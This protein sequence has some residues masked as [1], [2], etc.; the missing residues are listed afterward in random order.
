MNANA[1]VVAVDPG[2]IPGVAVLCVINGVLTPSPAV[3]QCGARSVAW[4]VD[5]MFSDE[6]LYEQRILVIERFVVGPRAARSSTPKAGQLTRDMVGELTA[7]GTQLGVRVVQRSA[8]EVM[9]WATDARLDRA[10]LL[11]VTKGMQHARAA[12]RHALFCAVRDCGASDPLS[13]RSP[14]ATRDGA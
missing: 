5:Q 1:L 6:P 2:P 14:T 3:F 11:A 10:G 8:S 9:P 12:A 7:L 4:L 13:S